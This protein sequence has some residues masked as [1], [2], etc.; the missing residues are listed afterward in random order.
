MFR[1]IRNLNTDELRKRRVRAEYSG[2][3]GRF[4]YEIPSYAP[5]ADN[6]VLIRT[7]YEKLTPNEREILFM[8][9]IMGMKY[10]EAASV[11]DVPQGTVMS[12]IS[13]ARRSLL[14]LVGPAEVKPLVRTDLK[15]RK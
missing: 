1:I 14:D 6:V 10:A 15:K 7:A 13:R 11:L 8:V 4:L 12:R 3:H 9:D 5:G 2:V